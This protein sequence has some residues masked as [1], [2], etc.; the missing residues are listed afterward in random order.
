[1]LTIVEDLSWHIWQLHQIECARSYNL[2][3]KI[4]IIPYLKP[5]VCIA[6][7]LQDELIVPER[8]PSAFMA[9]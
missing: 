5:H 9:N 7:W 6:S 2:I 8:I 4:I 3:R 1:M